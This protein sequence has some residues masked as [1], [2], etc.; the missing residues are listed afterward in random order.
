MT[1][2]FSGVWYNELGSKMTLVADKNG[3]LSGTYESAV[4]VAVDKY[5]LAGRYDA[6]PPTDGRGLTIAWAVSFRNDELNAHSTTG[7]SGQ[8]FHDG[9]ERILTHWLLTTSTLPKDVWK[10]TRVGHDTFTRTKPSAHA[11]IAKAQALTID[12]PDPDDIL[13]R[14]FHFKF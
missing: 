7:W 2:K 3:G 5:I 8:Y 10:S 6:S 13:S 1:E 11:E 14:F 9:T 4:G 12:S